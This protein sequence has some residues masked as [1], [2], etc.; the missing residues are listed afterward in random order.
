MSSKK[1][2]KIF[3]KGGPYEKNEKFQN[4]LKGPFEKILKIFLETK[5]YIDTIFWQK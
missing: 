3:S 4:F 5:N 2:F 1:I